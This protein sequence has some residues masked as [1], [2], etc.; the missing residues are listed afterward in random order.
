MFV[1]V[2][3]H[4]YRSYSHLPF[5]PVAVRHVSELLGESCFLKI[6]DGERMSNILIASDLKSDLHYSQVQQPLTC[7][8]I[9]RAAAIQILLF[10]LHNTR[11]YRVQMYVIYLALKKRRGKNLLSVVTF[12]PKEHAVAFQEY[13]L[14][15]GI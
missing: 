7:S 9:V 4:T 12:L 8:V 14:V 11:S 3:D 15:S 5:H 1:V 6:S 10:L 13:L 2:L